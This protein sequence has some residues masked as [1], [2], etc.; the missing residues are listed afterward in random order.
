MRTFIKQI[1]SFIIKIFRWISWNLY[2][3]TP[4]SYRRKKT[5]NKIEQAIYNINETIN[6]PHVKFLDNDGNNLK[7][8]PSRKINGKIAVHIHLYYLDLLKEFYSYLENIPF[9]FDVFVSTPVHNNIGIIKRKLRKIR[10][11]N[12]VVVKH[13]SNI[14]RDFGPMFFLF[15]KDI[16]QYKYLLH[17]H[18]K[19]SLRMGCEQNGWRKYLLGNLIGDSVLIMNY[20][21]LMEA[22]NV[23]LCY[24]QAFID[25]PCW[26][27]TWLQSFDI[28]KSFY[29]M[30]DIKDEYLSFSP[31][32]MFWCKVDAL[33][34]LFDMNLTEEDFGPE[35]GQDEGTLA[36]TLERVTALLAKHNKL[37]YAV[38]Y[39]S[40]RLIKV[41]YDDYNFY[42]NRVMNIDDLVSKCCDTKTISFGLFGTLINRIIEDEEMYISELDNHISKLFG[43]NKGEYLKYRKNAISKLVKAKEYEYIPP[44]DEI[45]N[46]I[47]EEWNINTSTIKKIRKEEIEF[48]IK[49]MVPRL[50][51]ISVFNTLKNLDRNK[52]IDIIS[53]TY[54][55]TK[56]I[57]YILNH[58]HIKGYDNLCLASV[59]GLT[60]KSFKLWDYYFDF[61]DCKTDLI[62]IAD[63][64]TADINY[65][66][67]SLVQQAFIPNPWKLYHLS[68]VNYN[69]AQNA[70]ESI[71]LGTIVNNLLN[72][73][74]I[75]RDDL[76]IA[77]KDYS[78]YGFCVIA[79][80]MYIFLRLL[81][82]QN[83][84]LKNYDLVYDYIE[85]NIIKH[86]VNAPN[87][88]EI[89]N[90][91][92]YTDD[93]LDIDDCHKCYLESYLNT[94][95]EQLESEINKGINNFFADLNAKALAID[96][97]MFNLNITKDYILQTFINI[98][99]GVVLEMENNNGK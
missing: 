71:F 74:F 89:N 79:P 81:T 99:N 75:L 38:F 46:I 76:K 94:N 54:Y 48:D 22:E 84:K 51:V 63:D 49:L 43:F 53:D 58:F 18:T 93:M 3:F 90:K 31:G 77:I 40:E 69:Y 32:S 17:I 11:C 86:T 36:H 47:Q 96:N 7:V 73:P 4:K 97:N 24:P 35:E 13:S 9:E 30:L 16:S 14:G 10:F 80:L 87:Y 57:E 88:K 1:I 91:C 29:T 42:K 70:D 82:K 34:Q 20:I 8:K 78:T 52:T 61:V 12:K 25:I 95:D 45:Y 21:N 64:E 37:D 6:Y 66:A 19:K 67:K 2:C 92:T 56:E 85:R 98:I 68:K 62:H 28:A 55:S 27:H 44:L 65:L 59:Q 60:K 83:I 39:P 26:G 23:G 15:G 33:R 5:I 72:S 50:D 41:N